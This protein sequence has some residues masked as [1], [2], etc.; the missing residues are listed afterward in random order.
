MDI[1][2]PIITV[3]SKVLPDSTEK[4]QQLTQVALEIQK[5]MQAQLD[6]QKKVLVAE[7]SGESVLQRIWRPV[8]MLSFTVLIILYWL[9]LVGSAIDN[10]I[11]MELLSIVKIGLGGYIV[12]RTGEKMMKEYKK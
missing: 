5:I 6:T 4:Q 2:T 12:G 10:S 8:V 1:L 7:L 11:I 9:G 3:L